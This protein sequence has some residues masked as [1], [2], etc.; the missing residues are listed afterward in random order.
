MFQKWNIITAIKRGKDPGGN[1]YVNIEDADA[2]RRQGARR[3][4]TRREYV[5]DELEAGPP[6]KQKSSLI[7]MAFVGCERS[8][9]ECSGV[10][11]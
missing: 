11:M 6:R 2:P 1:K 8:G 3:A 10:R 5:T 9:R 7:E 4:H